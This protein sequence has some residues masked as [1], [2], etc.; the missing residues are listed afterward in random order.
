MTNSAENKHGYHISKYHFILQVENSSF[1]SVLV[2]EPET[3]P[4][5]GQFECL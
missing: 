1:A 2:N 3:L 4:N 5:H